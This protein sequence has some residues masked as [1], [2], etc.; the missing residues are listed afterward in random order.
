MKQT[1]KPK[2][3]EKMKSPFWRFELSIDSVGVGRSFQ[4]GVINEPITESEAREMLQRNYG[5]N[6]VVK[7]TSLER[8]DTPDL[9]ENETLILRTMIDWDQDYSYGYAYL[10]ET[11]I[12]RK[13][14]RKT[15]KRLR[16]LGL[17]KISRGG[18]NEDGE[19]VGG[20]GFYIP[21][22]MLKTVEAMTKPKQRKS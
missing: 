14:L 10:E 15:I 6:G 11:G 13:E 20:T 22:E 19:V 9:S 21:Y 18:I 1:P 3:E 7:I 4:N 2:Q 17:V 16:E 12:D 8:I 5:I